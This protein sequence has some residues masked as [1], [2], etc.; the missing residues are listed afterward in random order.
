MEGVENMAQGSTLTLHDEETT[1]EIQN[2]LN[3]SESS[4]AGNDLSELNS[5]HASTTVGCTP[6]YGYGYVP[7]S[8]N[9]VC[10][11]LD[12]SEKPDGV[13]TCSALGC[14]YNTPNPNVAPGQAVVIA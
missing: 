10:V 13:I 5:N 11:P 6:G 12:G 7:H 9:L 2:N 8:P 1:G 3:G 4:S 14:Q